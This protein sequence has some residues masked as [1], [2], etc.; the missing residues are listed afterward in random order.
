MNIYESRIKPMRSIVK[1]VTKTGCGVGIAIGRRF[2]LWGDTYALT[3]AHVVRRDR[4]VHV[5]RLASDDTPTPASVIVSDVDHDLA[6]LHLPTC[7]E[8]SVIPVCS[9]VWLPINEVCVCMSQRDNR[10]IVISTTTTAKRKYPTPRGMCLVTDI[11]GFKGKSGSPL[12]ARNACIGVCYGH[13]DETTVYVSLQEIHPFLRTAG[14]SWL[15]SPTP[16]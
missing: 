6:L 9:S 10:P 7:L 3:A 8:C 12:I 11:T 1:V 16:D 5:R 13:L 4:T 14:F 15:L 2:G